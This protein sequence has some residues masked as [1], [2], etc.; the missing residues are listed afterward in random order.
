VIPTAKTIEL[1]LENRH[2]GNL[3]SVIA[4]VD[5][6]SKDLFKWPNKFSWSYNGE[7]AD[8]MMKERVKA[9]GG[10][11]DGDLRFSLQWNENNEDRSIDLDAHCVEPNGNRIYFPNRGERHRSSGTLDVDIRVPGAKV[12]VENITYYDRKKMPKGTYT[13]LVNN[14]SSSRC[15]AGFS[16]EIELDGTVHSLCY[17]RP[18]TGSQTVIVAEVECDGNGNFKINPKL[19]SSM[20]SKTAWTLPTQQFHRVSLILNSPNHWDGHPVGN[21]HFF[22]VLDGCRNDSSARGFY[23]EFLNSEMDKHRKVLELIGGKT[24]VAPSDQ[25]LSGLGFSSTQ[26]NSVLCRVV[27]ATDRVVKVIF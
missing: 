5:P 8:S 26:R 22:F 27:G 23:N 7:V 17:N 12:A 10:K 6:T 14:Y 13:L 25:Q 1:M 18:M 2:V 20:T 15:N 9:A 19:E 24:K 4:P 3:V 21:R 16:A 11:I